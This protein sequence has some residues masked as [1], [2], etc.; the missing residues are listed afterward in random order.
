[1]PSSGRCANSS[2]GIRENINGIKKE[3]PKEVTLLAATKDRT[4]EEIKEAIKSGIAV[5]GENYVQE[6]EKKYAALKNKA[7]FHFIG[8]LQKN[9]IKKVLEICS[10]IQSVDS[11]GLAEEMDKK[12][13]NK[14][15]ILLQVNIGKEKTK[16]GILPGNLVSEIKKISKLHNIRIKGLMCIEPYS[17]NP[18]DARPYFKEMKRLFDAVKKQGIPGVEMKILSMGMSDTYRIAVEEGSTLVRIG[19]AIFGERKTI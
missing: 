13:A 11:A 10:L 1:M 7:A 8:R 14:A 5:I 16:G 3:I 4:V 2:M 15:D 9:K 12:A 17:E 19:T 6:A 18:E